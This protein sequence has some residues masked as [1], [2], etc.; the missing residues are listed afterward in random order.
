MKKMAKD[1]EKRQSCYEPLARQD[2]QACLAER[3]CATAPPQIHSFQMRCASLLSTRVL[4][5]QVAHLCVCVCVCVC[6]YVCVCVCVCMSARACVQV[7][8]VPL[9]AQTQACE[10]HVLEQWQQS[11]AKVIMHLPGIGALAWKWSR[12]KNLK[13]RPWCRRSPG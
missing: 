13:Q 5:T 7:K 6:V 12:N 9:F 1:W 8:C 11:G 3:V 2:D 10:L 4:A